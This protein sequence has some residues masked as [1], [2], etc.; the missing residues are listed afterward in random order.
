MW[1]CVNDYFGYCSGTPN[2]PDIGQ[3]YRYL[4]IVGKYF[5]GIIERRTCQAD[6]KTC[7]H[8]RTSTQVPPL[9][10]ISISTKE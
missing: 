7:P 3:S 4:D 2:G 10:C 6:P 1:R 9:P 8:Y 5:P